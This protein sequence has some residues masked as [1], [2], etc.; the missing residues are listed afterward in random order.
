MQR[1]RGGLVFISFRQTEG[2]REPDYGEDHLAE[3][4]ER[5]RFFAG[6]RVWGLG[7]RG[8]GS[9]G[10]VF[11]GLVFSVEGMRVRMCFVENPT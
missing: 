8:K 1:F 11:L 5:V 7:V 2:D 6:G 10:L 4:R 9:R 3:E